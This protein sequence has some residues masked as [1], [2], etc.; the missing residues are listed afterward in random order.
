MRRWLERDYVMLTEIPGRGLC[1]LQRMAYTTGLFCGL[2]EYPYVGRYCYH[3]FH[4][5]VKDILKWNGQSDPPGNWIKHK[6]TTEYPNPN[7]EQ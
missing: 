2:D 3:T 7:Y 4:E 5:A 1:G 6:G